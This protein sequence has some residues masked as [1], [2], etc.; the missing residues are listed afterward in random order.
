M[1][2]LNHRSPLDPRRGRVRARK[3][4]LLFVNSLKLLIDHLAGESIDR[5][6]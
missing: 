4:N 6:M 1:W 2:D 3:T 5:D